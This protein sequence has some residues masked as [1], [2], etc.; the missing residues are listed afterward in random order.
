MPVYSV[1]TK[2]GLLD[3]AQREKLAVGITAIH[4]E[5]TGAP[6]PLIH[7]IFNGYPDG[8][9][10]SA[11]RPG[12][13]NIINAS[14]RAGRSEEVRVRMMTRMSELMCEVAGVS[15]R[16]VIVALFDFPPHWGMEAGMVLP[17]TQKEAETAWDAAFYARYPVD[18]QPVD[19]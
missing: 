3:A 7:V 2:I 1:T 10:W 4:S 17:P 15:E 5:E 13:P 6:E 12:A 8:V 14:I 19:A 9:A 11:C 18:N 16:D